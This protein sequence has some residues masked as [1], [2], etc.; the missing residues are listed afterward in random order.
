MVKKWVIGIVISNLGF[1]LLMFLLLVMISAIV[2]SGGASSK[3]SDGSSERCSVV[4]S[5]KLDEATLSKFL[6]TRGV[7]KGTAKTF[8]KYGEEYNVD[9]ALVV[10]IA[11]H[12]TGNGKSRMVRKLNNPGGLMGDGSG[13]Q[14]STL[15]KGIEAMIKNLAKNYI[16][17][18]LNTPE[19]IQPKYA[20]VGAA[21]DGLGLNKEWI[22]GVNGFLKQLGGLSTC[23]TSSEGTGKYIIPVDNPIVSS[24]FVDRVNPV[25]G[26]AEH[27]KGL[28]FAQ[29]T[30]SNIKAADD[31]VVLVA[32]MGVSGSGF[33]GYGNV[34]LIEHTKN[35][36]WT[37]YGHQSKILVKPGQNVKKGEVIGLVGSTGQST[38]PHLHFEIRQEKMGKQIDPAPVLGVKG[39]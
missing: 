9:P 8:I 14:F 13:F 29:P 27:H 10:A 4:A 17:Q 36:E 38:G 7:F 6:E 28:D 34:V 5:G 32:Q 30:G 35:K 21:N 31:G 24:G 16:T 19:K 3:Q 33:G 12:E 15:D 2:T 39:K 18:G 20:P 11:M 25:T 37:L 26:V 22:T 23:A 1:F